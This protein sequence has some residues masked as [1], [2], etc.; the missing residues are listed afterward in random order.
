MRFTT[1]IVLH[2]SSRKYLGIAAPHVLGGE[3][4]RVFQFIFIYVMRIHWEDFQVLR[5][6]SRLVIQVLEGYIVG[7][8][9]G[10]IEISRLLELLDVSK[11]SNQ[12]FLNP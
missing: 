8:F 1:Q 2:R 12:N 9:G 3:V 6:C 5:Y 7:K 4:C 11:L 10:I